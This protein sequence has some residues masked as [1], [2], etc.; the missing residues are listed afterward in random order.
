MPPITEVSFASLARGSRNANE[1]RWHALIFTY[2]DD[3]ADGRRER[4]VSTGGIIGS[5]FNVDYFEALWVAETKH[6]KEPFRSTECEC[7]KGQFEKWSKADCDALIKKLVDL[8]CHSV[9]LVGGFASVVPVPLYNEVFPGSHEDDPY[10][11]TVAHTI[12]EMARIASR[13]RELIKLWFEDSS[14]YHALIDRTYRELKTLKTWKFGGRDMLFGISFDDKSLAPLQAADLVAREAFKASD[15]LGKREFRKPLLRMWSRAG[16][17][18][19]TKVSLEKLKGEGWPDNLS[20]IVSLSDAAYLQ[21][22]NADA[23]QFITSK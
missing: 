9:Q 13:A 14:E 21:V 16:M 6:L 8:I 4:Y 23:T 7:Q 12:V 10:R 1:S 17:I 20:A 19:W 22:R 5:E 11:L 15:N 2:F 3:S 18:L